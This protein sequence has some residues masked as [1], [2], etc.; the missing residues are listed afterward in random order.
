MALETYKINYNEICEEI[1]NT[2]KTKPIE[3]SDYETMNTDTFNFQFYWDETH[4]SYNEAK[5]FRKIIK[6]RLL[7]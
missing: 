7:K 2:L 5:A 1:L 4:S 3:L 6:N